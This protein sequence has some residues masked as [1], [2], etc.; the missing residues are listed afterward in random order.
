MLPDLRPEARPRRGDSQPL[1][2][3]VCWP[4]V[5]R[6]GCLQVPVPLLP[7]AERLDAP[8]REIERADSPRRKAVQPGWDAQQDD[9]PAR[10]QRG[11]WTG[12]GSLRD[13]ATVVPRRPHVLHLRPLVPRLLRLHVRLHPRVQKRRLPR[14]LLQ[15][16]RQ[17]EELWIFSRCHLF[18]LL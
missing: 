3:Q 11:S 18:Y 2:H 1:Q 9:S 16:T 10:V 4:G 12:C 6:D 17:R 15:G 7:P 14:G 5:G 13:L 8:R